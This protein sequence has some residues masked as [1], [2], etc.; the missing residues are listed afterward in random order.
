MTMNVTDGQEMKHKVW[1]TWKKKKSENVR[2]GVEFKLN[3][4]WHFLRL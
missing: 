4:T 2:L 1:L 3:R